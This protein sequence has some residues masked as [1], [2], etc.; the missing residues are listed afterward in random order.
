MG[1]FADYAVDHFIKAEVKSFDYDDRKKAELWV[2][3]GLAWCS[4]LVN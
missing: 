4:P 2:A 3:V 1:K